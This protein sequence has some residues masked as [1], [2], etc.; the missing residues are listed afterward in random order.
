MSRHRLEKILVL[1]AVAASTCAQQSIAQEFRSA[2]TGGITGSIVIEAPPCHVFKAIKK[3]RYEEPDR[4]RVESSTGNEVVLYENF[5]T[6]PIIGKASCRYKEVESLDKRIDYALI[7][8]NQFRS[9]HGAWELTPLKGGQA[10]LL[11]L[12]SCIDTFVCVPFKRQLTN[13]GTKKDISRRLN[14]IKRNVE[15]SST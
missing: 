8:S 4:R 12:T 6:L 2:D 5:I 14:N 1:Y 15:H 9:F 7:D 13:A 11:K 3:S 10:T